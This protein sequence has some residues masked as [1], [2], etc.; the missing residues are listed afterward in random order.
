M[1]GVEFLSAENKMFYVIPMDIT[2]KYMYNIHNKK[3]EGSQSLTLSKNQLNTNESNN[4]RDETQ[5]SYKTQRKQWTKG[6]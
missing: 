2:K 5:E 6:M 3:W 4:G 1:Y